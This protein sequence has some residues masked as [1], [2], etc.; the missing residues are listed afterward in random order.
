MSSAISEKISK[1]QY[2]FLKNNKIMEAIGITREFFHS[3]KSKKMKSSILKMD[4]SKYYD[5]VDWGFLHLVL[6]QIGVPL[7]VSNWILTYVSS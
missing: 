7:D 4:L 6:L 3:A 5:K 1:E 2:G